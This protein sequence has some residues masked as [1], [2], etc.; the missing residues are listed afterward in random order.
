MYMSPEQAMGETE[1]DFRSDIYSVGATMYHVLGGRPPF[2][3]VTFREVIVKH[4][5]EYPL[6]LT[7]IS[8]NTP[9]FLSNIVMKALQKKP[10]NRF[11]TAEELKRALLLMATKAGLHEL[12]P[13]SKDLRRKPFLSNSRSSSIER[14]RTTRSPL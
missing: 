7:S 11:Q 13:L 2:Q 12:R 9:H 4:I 1:I 5:K 8:P 10:E 3:A 14:R 6:P